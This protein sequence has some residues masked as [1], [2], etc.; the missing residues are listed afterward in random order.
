MVH[1]SKCG[2]YVC[3]IVIRM[4]DDQIPVGPIVEVSE[5]HCKRC[6][7]VSSYTVIV[8]DKA[9]RKTVED[10]LRA[11]VTPHKKQKLL[12]APKEKK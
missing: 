8:R 3:T 4:D 7:F 12:P 6:K 9:E 10:R 1:C 2:R 5:I 11:K